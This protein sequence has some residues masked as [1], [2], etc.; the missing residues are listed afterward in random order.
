MSTTKARLDRDA[1]V[2]ASL[3][4]GDLTGAIWTMGF[5]SGDDTIRT[6]TVAAVCDAVA[7]D[8]INAVS[9]ARIQSHDAG[10]RGCR[11]FLLSLSDEELDTMRQM[12]GIIR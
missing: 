8:R 3:A 7:A 2:A 4:S 9:R 12:Y 1:R 10:W 5:A 11:T 6:D